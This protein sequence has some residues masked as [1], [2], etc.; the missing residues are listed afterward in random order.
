MK[1]LSQLL[2]YLGCASLCV[3]GMQVSADIAGDLNGDG[4]L[5]VGDV[6]RI[7]EILAGNVA[8]EPAADLD[9][10]G[11]VTGND[12]YLL[13]EA[14][15][16]MPLPTPLAAGVIGPGGGTLS[17][18]GVELTVPAGVLDD[19]V[20]ISICSDSSRVGL[21][22]VTPATETFLIHGI[23]GGVEGAE[24]RLDLPVVRDDSG[25]LL[26]AGELVIPNEGDR[27]DWYYHFQDDVVIAGNQAIWTLP[28]MPVA[29]DGTRDYADE[30]ARGWG[31]LKLTLF[32][33]AMYRV[34][35]TE[36][37]RI[38][39]PD[40]LNPDEIIQIQD[41]GGHMEAA[42]DLVKAQGFTFDSNWYRITVKVK[43]MT[44]KDG[45]FVPYMV[46]GGVGHLEINR[47]TL[48]NAGLLRIVAA[49]EFFHY[50]QAAFG[51]GVQE[52]WLDEAASTWIEKRMSGSASYVPSVWL[53]N[54]RAPFNGM[55]HAV[56][57]QFKWTLNP[58][59]M[60]NYTETQKAAWNHGYGMSAFFEYL[61]GRHDWDDGYWGRV[62]GHVKAGEPPVSAVK[63]A[64]SGTAAFDNLYEWFLRDYS[65]GKVPYVTNIL[66]LY[67]KDSNTSNEKFKQTA[68]AYTIAT[69]EDLLEA[70]EYTYNVQDIGGATAIF[71]IKKPRLI[72]PGTMLHVESAEHCDWLVGMRYA[73]KAVTEYASPEYDTEERIWTLDI[74][75]DYGETTR[76]YVI[77]LVAMNTDEYT[78][79]TD[80]RDVKVTVSFTLPPVIPPGTVTWN[81]DGEPFMQALAGGSLEVAPGITGLFAVE[82]IDLSGPFPGGHS[83]AG[84]RNADAVVLKPFPQTMRLYAD[85]IPTDMGQITVWG[86]TKV[87][88]IPNGMAL[89]EA[90]VEGEIVSSVRV[91]LDDLRPVQGEVTGYEFTIPQGVPHYVLGIK[92]LADTAY[93]FGASGTSESELPLFD[94][95]FQPAAAAPE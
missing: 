29:E 34:Y 43:K 35:N 40:S 67:S 91:P 45:V 63:K 64:Y 54:R 12:A 23:P 88:A 10:D 25:W 18:T 65:A 9:G 80:V 86:D 24:I 32:Q 62:Y 61:S 17:G 36:H 27:A 59:Q 28:T 69:F 49:H 30:M 56:A 20:T 87:H 38:Y 55:D 85:I 26:A 11:A 44:G 52:S 68:Q 73:G 57:R 39:A 47:A 8:A 5:N 70:Y 33:G 2:L 41:L 84:V 22:E 78:P 76:Q 77:G 37:F 51:S 92:M 48:A 81:W 15:R 50:V 6:V 13:A 66:S 58:R 72:P 95:F 79:H 74:E 4:Q 82:T 21:E 53:R 71:R 14:I 46:Y 3:C 60:Y 31:V 83:F 1:R 75:L 16:G 19:E 90:V 94:I 89:I 42:H 93:T 7:H